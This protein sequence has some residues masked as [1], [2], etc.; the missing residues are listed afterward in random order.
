MH[1]ALLRQVYRLGY[2]ALL[3]LSFVRTPRGRGAKGL[4]TNGGELLLVRH[5]YG[6]REWELPGGGARRREDAL[7]TLRRELREELG[8]E[9]DGVDSLGT[10]PGRGRYGRVRVSYFAVELSDRA[11]VRDP[12]EIA[13]V[14]WFDPAALPRPLGWHAKEAIAR[15]GEAVASRASDPGSPLRG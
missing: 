4:L 15:H 1:D 3:G 5:T 14:A 10:H 12:V 11:V 9:V 7:A 2:W 8:V 13:E 6:P